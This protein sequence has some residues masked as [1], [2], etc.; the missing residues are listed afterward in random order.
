MNLK[1]KE[2]ISDALEKWVDGTELPDK[3]VEMVKKYIDEDDEEVLQLFELVPASAEGEREFNPT[4]CCCFSWT[5][6][7]C[8]WTSYK[9]CT[10]FGGSDS[11]GNC[12]VEP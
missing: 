10:K 6:L 12:G 8:Q 7:K 5:N 4:V 9:V 3:I 1:D 11:P 2:T